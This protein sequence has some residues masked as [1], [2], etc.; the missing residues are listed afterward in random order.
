MIGL[1]TQFGDSSSGLGALGISPQAFLIQ[2]ITFIIA[3]L[4][5]RKWAFGPILKVLN[6]RRQLIESG[7]ELGEKMQAQE[8]QTEADIAEKLHHATQQAD[9]IVSE[10]E[11]T[12]KQ[13]VQAA[14]EAARSRA[15][16]I[17][18]EAS[19]QLKQATERERKRLEKDIVGLVSEVSEAI[20]GEKVDAQKDASLIDRAL[21]DRQSA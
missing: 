11:A 5:L 10:A 1:L 2:L 19:E 12:A 16:L 20:I 9:N 4:A 13:T 6:E 14:E 3:F 17:A 8:K 15:E 21:K 7:I 18:R